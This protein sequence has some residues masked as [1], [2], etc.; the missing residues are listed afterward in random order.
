M[1]PD[2]P[3]LPGVEHRHVAVRGIRIHIAEAG[4]GDPVVLQHG[5]PQAWWCWRKVIPVLAERYRVIV[6]DLRG[7]GWSEE[8]A[9][10][11]EKESLAQDLIALLDELG[12]ERVRLVGHDWGAF[13]GFLACL[14]APERFDRFV[15]LS[16]LHPWIRPNLRRLPTYTYQAVISAPLLGPLTVRHVPLFVSTVFRAGLA[17]RDAIDP[18]SLALY[19]A[20]T[21]HHYRSTVALYRTFLL[22][23]ARPLLAGAYRDRRLTVPTRLIAG[24][25]DP[26]ISPEVLTGFEDHADDMAVEL[27][28]GPGHF[29]PEEDPEQLTRRLLDF[30]A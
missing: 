15:A 18:E 6:P 4:A 30:F 19:L 5:W 11:Y 21:R 8:P 28:A 10:G 27:I 7:H 1:L 16:M 25:R 13:A 9:S 3:R 20:L 23:E 2:L 12:H 29:L 24:D 14:R 26:V 22:R 17:R